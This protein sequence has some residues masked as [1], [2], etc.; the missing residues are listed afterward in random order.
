MQYLVWVIWKGTMIKRYK[1]WRQNWISET[2]KISLFEFHI[3]LWSSDWKSKSS[4][5]KYLGLKLI[6]IIS[7]QKNCHT[8]LTVMLTLRLLGDVWYTKWGTIIHCFIVTVHCCIL[9]DTTQ[10]SSYIKHNPDFLFRRYFCQHSKCSFFYARPTVSCL[11]TTFSMYNYSNI[12][13]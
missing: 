7:N 1:I 4:S 9:Y 13:L 3:Q 5:T 11:L 6:L 2:S 10:G 12:V 8:K